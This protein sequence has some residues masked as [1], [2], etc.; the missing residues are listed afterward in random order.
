M[1]VSTAVLGAAKKTTTPIKVAAA[2][3]TITNGLITVNSLH[4]FRFLDCRKRRAIAL[5]HA[6]VRW[7]T[8]LIERRRWAIR[9][10]RV[11]LVRAVPESQQ[12]SVICV[13]IPIVAI[14]S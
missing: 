4:R 13:F 11:T 14:L 8:A 10:Y 6:I 12:P 7:L 2:K 5:D 3:P 1:L 9:R